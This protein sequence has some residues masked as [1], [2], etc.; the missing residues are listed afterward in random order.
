MRD[1]VENPVRENSCAYDKSS[2]FPVKAA[3]SGEKYLVSKIGNR[4]DVIEKL[5]RNE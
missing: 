1:E 5:N 2:V 3:V 4:P